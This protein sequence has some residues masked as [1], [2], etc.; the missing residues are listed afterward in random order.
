MVGHGRAIR[1]VVSDVR[2]FKV[3]MTTYVPGWREMDKQRGGS[4]YINIKQEAA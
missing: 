1:S 4:R 3:L 2:L